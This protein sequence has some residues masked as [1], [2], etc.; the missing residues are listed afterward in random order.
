MSSGK[1]AGQFLGFAGVGAIATLLQ[2]GI[3]V[4]TVELFGV[5][6]V[7]GS[8]LGFVVSAILNYL[9]NYHFTFRSGNS[10]AVAASRFAVVASGGLAINASVM[11]LLMHFTRLPYVVS[12]VITTLV[13][14]IW[15]FAGNALWSFAAPR[16]N[17]ATGAAQGRK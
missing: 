4:L 17:A 12:Q 13:V 9:L 5:P 14:L 16:G 10:H 15:N 2:Y 3:L 6:A 1:F 8:C 7:V 11:G